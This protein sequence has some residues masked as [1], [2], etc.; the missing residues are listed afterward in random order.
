MIS[1]D[2]YVDDALVSWIVLLTV[3]RVAYLDYLAS[4]SMISRYTA[5]LLCTR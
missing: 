3:V 5:I 4:I 1:G 2:S